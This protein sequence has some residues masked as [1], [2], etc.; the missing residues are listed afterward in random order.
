MTKK[1]IAA[2]AATT[3]ALGF[4]YTIIALIFA[5]VFIIMK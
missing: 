3:V 5:A 2:F 4:G 1:H